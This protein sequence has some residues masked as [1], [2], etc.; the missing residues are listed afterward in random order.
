MP[1]TIGKCKLLRIK[2]TFT[3]ETFFRNKHKIAF[4]FY[5]LIKCTLFGRNVLPR[6]Q[7]FPSKWL[8]KNKRVSYVNRKYNIPPTL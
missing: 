2:H 8:H 1:C 7:R 5:F 4:F 6:P 3:N